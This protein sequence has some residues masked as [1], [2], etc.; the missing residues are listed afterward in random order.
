MNSNLMLI[1]APTTPIEWIDQGFDITPVNPNTK[2][3]VL[4]LRIWPDF[5]CTLKD[6]N[7]HKSWALKLDDYT[8]LDIDNP[9]AKLFIEKYLK[10][11]GA[12]YGRKGNLRSH[13]LFKNKSNMTVFDMPKNLEK[14]CKGYPHGNHLGQIRSGNKYLSIV[15]GALNKTELVE[16]D[17]YIGIDKYDGDLEKDFAKIMLSTALTLCYP[18]RK[19]Q[20]DYCFAIACI[21]VDNTKWS[22]E[23]IDEFVFEIAV[24]SGDINSRDRMLKG[25][26]SRNSEKNKIGLDMITKIIGTDKISIISL[27]RWIN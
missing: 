1:N 8:D 20:N 16:W 14:Y 19:D 17:K 18:E 11:Y 21:L 9:K 26:I 24:Q 22:N 2:K 15:P 4:G 5:K 6:F 3:P 23:E 12:R 13:Y 25:T 7:G 10:F 27:F